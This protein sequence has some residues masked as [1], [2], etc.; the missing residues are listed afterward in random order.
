[1]VILVNGGTASASEVLTSSLQDNRLAYVIGTKTYG[2]GVVQEL[3]PL[4]KG[5]VLKL[6]VEEYLSPNLRKINGKGI[7]PDLTIENQDEQLLKAIAYLNGSTALRLFRDGTAAIA[8]FPSGNHVAKKIDGK[9]F[10]ALRSFAGLY[11]Y[12]I[13]WNAAKGQVTLRYG[14]SSRTY[15]VKNNPHL[16][17]EKGMLWISLDKLDQ[18]FSSIVV[19]KK[20]K[21]WRVQVKQSQ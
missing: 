14:S 21:E 19:E 9:W 8:G 18:D 13:D 1:M 3:I 15:S 4:K 16:R 17:N 20:E 7:I 12:K 2:K 6:T 10:I 5:G 11:G